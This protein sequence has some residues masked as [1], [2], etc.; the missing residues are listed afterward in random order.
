MQN[1]Q[2]KEA[3]NLQKRKGKTEHDKGR[4]AQKFQ[5]VAKKIVC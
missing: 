4:F 2:N 3:A 5:G 1:A